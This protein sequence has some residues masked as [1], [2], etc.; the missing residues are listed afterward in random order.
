LQLVLNGYDKRELPVMYLELSGKCTKCRCLYCD[1]PQ[2][3]NLENELSLDEIKSLINKLVNKRLR[4]IFICGLGEPSEDEKLK[5]LLFYL[6]EREIRVSF[7]TNG[8]GFAENDIRNLIEC[9]ANLILK[10]D[11]FHGDIFNRLLG[12]KGTAEKIYSFLESLLLYG[13]VKVKSNN[14]TNLALSIVPTALN[15]SSIPEVVRYC[16]KHS[17]YP[18]IGE[19]EPSGNAIKNLPDLRVSTVD[20]QE[21]HNKV[22]DILGYSYF[23]PLCPGVISDFRIDHVGNCIVDTITGLG[24]GWFL[25]EKYVPFILGNIRNDSIDDIQY[26]AFLYRCENFHKTVSMLKEKTP[27]IACGGGAR[28]SHW[29]ELYAKLMGKYLKS[30][31]E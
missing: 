22:S 10:L 8:L 4:W 6:K 14:E 30:N 28:P 13:F 11:T 7:F 18:A 2:R 15:L 1:S 26:R 12:K 25:E 27:V 20:L 5:P 17:I 21:I 31:E 9:D 16:F 29:V 24:C 19:M 23:R 3:M